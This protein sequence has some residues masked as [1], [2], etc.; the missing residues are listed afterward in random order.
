MQDNINKRI[1]TLKQRILED[2]L[3]QTQQAL[4][5]AVSV[6][7]GQFRKNKQGK[8]ISAI[9]HPVTVALHAAALGFSEDELLAAALL[10]DVLEDSSRDAL[11]EFFSPSVREAVD[12][13]TYRGRGKK[14]AAAMSAY[15]CTIAQNKATALIK[16]VDRCH[17]LATMSEGLTASQQKTY[18]KETKRYVLPMMAGAER[19]FGDLKRPFWL[20]RYQMAA[21]MQ[22][23]KDNLAADVL[24]PSI[25]KA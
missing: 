4:E 6:H 23:A 20:V 15:Y 3:E 21:V 10:H 17:N 9:I 1:D 11:P 16:A 19:H 25:V 13:L 18:I 8:V 5:L 24:A 14:D 7:A 12:I 2:G 22:T